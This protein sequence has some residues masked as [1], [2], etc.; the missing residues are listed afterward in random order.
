MGVLFIAPRLTAASQLWMRRMVDMV[1]DDLSLLIDIEALPASYTSRFETLILNQVGKQWPGPID[2][3]RRRWETHRHARTLA[4]AVARDDIDCVFI[5]FL[6]HAVRY[7]SVWQRTEKPVFVHC[8]G[9]DVSWDLQRARPGITGRTAVHPPGYRQAAVALPE[10]VTF[11]ANSQTTVAAIERIG[12]KADRIALKYLGVPCDR[13]PPQRLMAGSDPSRPL[14]ILYL[15]RFVDCKGPDTTIRA[16]ARAREKGLEA[17]LVMA[18]DGPLRTGCEQLVKALSLESH[19]FL[20]GAVTPAEGARLRAQ[21]DI[22]TAHNQTGV[23]SR[24]TEALG[25]AFL[26]AMAAGVPVV[27]GCS[28]SLPEIVENGVSGLLF[29]SG[30]IDAHARALIRLADDP[31]LRRRLGMAAYRRVKKDFS[32]DEEHR[33]LRLLLGLEKESVSESAK[34]R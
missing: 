33:A 28:G 10:N 2:R 3:L 31:A 32:L 17:T 14:Q 19:V 27:T 30:D 20:P 21:S 23:K 22:F 18:G 13:T 6:V 9:W 7:R 1:G 16:F 29:D 25:V 4:A 8:H 34:C 5:H 26:E 11:V 15:G 12:V 24:Q